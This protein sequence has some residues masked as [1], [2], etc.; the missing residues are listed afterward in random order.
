MLISPCL[1]PV[2]GSK[3]RRQ[4]LL[5]LRG[6]TLYNLRPIAQAPQTPGA[7]VL[8]PLRIALVNA[9]SLVS[10]TSIL[11]DFFI[12]CGLDFMCITETWMTIDESGAFSELLPPEV[13]ILAVQGRQVAEVI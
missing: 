8:A 3:E 12:S 11:K 9:R 5:S 10:K 4:T 6:V 7:Q 13:H 1:V 2:V